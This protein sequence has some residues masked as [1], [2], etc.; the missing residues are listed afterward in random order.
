M[1]NYFYNSLGVLVKEESYVEGE[2]SNGKSII[3]YVYSDKGFLIQ[4]IRYNSL[5]PTSKFYENKEYDDKNQLIAEYNE[6]GNKKEYTYNKNS[7]LL[8]K[9]K[10]SDESEVV[11]GYDDNE[12]LNS[13]SITDENNVENKNEIVYK[14]GVPVSYKCGDRE[15]YF[16]YDHKRRI[17]GFE[18]NQFIGYSKNISDVVGQNKT[19][20]TIYKMRESYKQDY[21]INEYFPDGRIK[22]EKYLYK[23]HYNY[24]PV[25]DTKVAYTYGT[26]DK[27]NN[28]TQIQDNYAN[29]THE[30]TY[31]GLDRV[32]KHKQNLIEQDIVYKDTGEIASEN[33]SYKNSE[34][35]ETRIGIYATSYSYSD[36]S[37]KKLKSISNLG[38]ENYKYDK[39]GRIIEKSIPTNYSYD[40]KEV[41]GYYK[42]GDRTTNIINSIKY[43]NDRELVRRELYTYDKNGNI[44]SQNDNGSQVKSYSYD[45]LGRLIK[46]K[47]IDLNK[48]ICYTY[49][50]QGNILSKTVN[51]EETIFSYGKG[52]S[53]SYETTS[54][55]LVRVG[56]QSISYDFIGNPTS[57]L[58]ANL[59]WTR[60][61]LLNSYSKNGVN[62]NFVYDKDK[63]LTKKTVGDV[64]TDYI[65]FDGKLIQEKTGDE[66]IKYYYGADGIRGF[67]HSTKGNFY[68]RKNVLGD[69]I[70]IIDSFGTVKGKYSYTAFGECTKPNKN[71]T[72]PW[73]CVVF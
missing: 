36:D 41:Y 55:N 15:Y 53:N 20:T 8:E 49:D 13:I 11:Y 70:E 34:S 29:I 22:E 48:E 39:L 51:D 25:F 21:F 72:K 30:F 46:E 35:D 6:F 3:E 14:Y 26:E 27:I 40:I 60:L 65:W 7:Y 23:D 32:V 62:A 19:V 16:T 57:Y 69:I 4:E 71:N 45:K 58:G 9:E 56:N 67:S 44:I 1:T 68:Y 28:V 12:N 43:F 24:N 38:T 64:V 37:Q 61:N 2:E 17:T 31:D 33:F 18:S 52:S 47:N 54:E 42:N 5:D 10:N 63:L 66:T 50:E 59:T 73:S